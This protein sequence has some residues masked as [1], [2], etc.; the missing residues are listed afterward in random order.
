VARRLRGVV[1]G[2]EEVPAPGAVLSSQDKEVGRLTS[3][4]WSPARRKPVA[5]AYVRR[6]V[7]PPADV[8]V[9]GPNGEV[10][11]RVEEL[12]LVGGAAPAPGGGQ[13]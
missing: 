5:L 9:S 12:P 13:A 8:T 2:D 4:A 1:I 6:D 3:V 11:G 7:V 10:P